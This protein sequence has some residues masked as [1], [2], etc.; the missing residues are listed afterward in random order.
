ML[1][2]SLPSR[3]RAVRAWVRLAMAC[4]LIGAVSATAQAATF[5]VNSSGDA[6]DAIPGN[7]V[8]ADSAGRCTLRAAVEE[9]N[10]RPGADVVTLPA[11][12]YALTAGQIGIT[13]TLTLSGS[14]AGESII[15]GSPIG[16]IFMIPGPFHVVI[17][18]V[19][20]QKG[21]D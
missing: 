7:G 20:I 16:R 4:A 14:G 12:S 18:G 21:F 1:D 3:V 19:T 15:S 13:D 5:I 17:S 2:P 9:A 8:C 6:A 10:A 11:G